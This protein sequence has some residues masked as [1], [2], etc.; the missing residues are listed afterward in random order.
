MFYK[1]IWDS[2]PV[3]SFRVQS[4]LNRF[5]NGK[6]LLRQDCGFSQPASTLQLHALFCFK[7]IN[8]R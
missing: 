6:N 2:I 8:Y 4:V 3:G 5:F 1:I 7:K